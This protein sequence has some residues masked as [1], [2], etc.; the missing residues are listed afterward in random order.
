[1][2][3]RYFTYLVILSADFA[4]RLGKISTKVGGHK[5]ID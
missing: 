5:F 3:L 4:E 2:G 1:M